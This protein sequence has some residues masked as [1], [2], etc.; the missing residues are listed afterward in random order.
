MAGLVQWQAAAAQEAFFATLSDLPLMVGLEELTDSALIFDTPGG[1]LV[2]FSAAGSVTR[3][4][5]LAFYGG[6]LPQ[7]GWRPMAEDRFEREGEILR[8][9][10]GAG[11]GATLVTFALAPAVAAAP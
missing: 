6:T 5:I 4:A 8:L 2:E 3:Q 1:R 10:F 11:D 7:L 9:S